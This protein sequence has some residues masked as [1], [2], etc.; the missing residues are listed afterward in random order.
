MGPHNDIY[1]IEYGLNVTDTAIK[2]IWIVSY[3]FHC[4][5]Q[6]LIRS[7]TKYEAFRDSAEFPNEI[8]PNNI[9]RKYHWMDIV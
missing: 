7:N 2:T 1:N 9:N 5:Q 3:I 8:Q 4:M 6:G